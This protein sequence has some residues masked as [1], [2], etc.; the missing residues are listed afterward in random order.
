M[1]Y[2]ETVYAA[3]SAAAEMGIPKRQLITNGFFSRNSA[4]IN[5]AAQSL[6]RAGINEILLSADAFH[7]ETIPLEPVQV[8]AEAAIEFGIRL[9]A[10][11][12]WVVSKQHN[13]PYNRRTAEI[14][15][16]FEQLGI[17][18]S[19][20]NVLNGNIY[21]MKILEILER[22]TPVKFITLTRK[23]VLYYNGSMIN[24]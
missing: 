4:V 23:K 20:G 16:E 1:L 22:Y 9:R 15:E 10:H 8:F 13:N 24:K 3:H 2:P 6:A 21:Q 7:Q 14:M 18:Q 5:Q 19:D 17:V 11:P 12:A